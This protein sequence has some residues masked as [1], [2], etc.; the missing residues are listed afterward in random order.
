MMDAAPS[1]DMGGVAESP[2]E[3]RAGRFRQF[4]LDHW[5]IGA[6]LVAAAVV[7]V[8]VML[9]YPPAFWFSDSVAYVHAAVFGR[10][11]L[12]RPV[13]YS[14]LLIMLKPFQSFF[15]V[16]VVQ[17]V[18]GLAMGAEVYALLRHQK[19]PAWASAL[20]ATPPLFS[21]TA[22]QIEHYVLSDTFFGFLVTSALVILLWRPRPR[23]WV[24]VLVGLLLAWS[25][26]DRPQGIL[27]M[28]PFFLYLATARLGWRRFL[29]GAIT[30]AATALIPVAAYAWWFDL[31]YGSFQLTTSTGA[32]LYSRV[33][34]FAQCSIVRPPRDE[35]FLC[36]DTP[37]GER[38]NSSWYVF[39]PGSPLSRG[40]GQRF[41]SHVNRLAIDFALRTI[42]AQPAT[43]LRVV[44][45]ASVE[46]F[47]PA[48][49]GIGTP[50]AYQ[51]TDSVPVLTRYE[52]AVRRYDGGVNPSTRVIQPFAGWLLTYQR[53][54]RLPGPLLGLI[55]AVG[56]LGIVLGRRR[57]GSQALV[58]WLTGAFLIVTPAATA[59][60]DARYV[61]ASVPAFCVAGAL[62]IWEAYLTRRRRR[63]TEANSPS[64]G[65]PGSGTD[66]PL[67]SPSGG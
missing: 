18:M 12:I 56:L 63:D 52:L 16:A 50:S 25:V 54:L 7:R 19:L 22:L 29:V 8:T 46:A 13:G 4:M 67:G 53:F 33:A 34:P 6:L 1:L 41:S 24:C 35:Q 48:G 31:S 14:F 66:D 44:W 9:A 21:A 17:N 42:A 62:G 49:L 2:A 3:V 51:F 43:Y 37:V 45:D 47:G 55:V 57:S 61:V 39:R 40:S 11:D 27:L 60:Y 58:A 26:V 64:L 10:P 15:L 65:T 36:I 32:F 38:H 23:I 20:A 59:D 30:L 28:V 5:L